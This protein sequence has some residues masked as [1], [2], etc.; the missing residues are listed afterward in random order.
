MEV[1]RLP[2]PANLLSPLLPFPARCG[3][4]QCSHIL[5]LCQPLEISGAWFTAPLTGLGLVDP[6]AGFVLLVLD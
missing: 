6:V 2:D 3:L 1:L 4:Y 5:C